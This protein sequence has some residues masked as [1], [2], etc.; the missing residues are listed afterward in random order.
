[1]RINTRM[2]HIS[3]WQYLYNTSFISLTIMYAKSLN[4]SYTVCVPLPNAKCGKLA[5]GHWCGFFCLF[6]KGQFILIAELL[7]YVSSFPGDG[8]K[9]FT[10]VV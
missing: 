8:V 3:V 7:H 5:H 4:W 6:F 9:D 10:L 1:M 2:S